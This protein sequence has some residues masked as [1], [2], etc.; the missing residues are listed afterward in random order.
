MGPMDMKF[1]KAD[2]PK[3]SPYV[4]LK[5]NRFIFEGSRGLGTIVYSDVF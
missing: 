2:G 5:G 1:Y 3:V 4:E